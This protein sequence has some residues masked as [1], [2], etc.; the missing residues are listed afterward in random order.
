MARLG[1]NE[2]TILPG[3]LPTAE[4]LVGRIVEISGALHQLDRDMGAASDG[5]LDARIAELRARGAT[6]SD[7]TLKLLLQQR[8][9]IAELEGRRTTLRSQLESASIAL[10]NLRLDV[11]RL[12]SLG[13]ESPAVHDVGQAT[14]QARAL[15]RDLAY[16]ME[17]AR[18]ADRV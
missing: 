5:S 17:G 4:A 2:R 16:L 18:E 13:L 3:V 6:E 15:S 12:G 7:S 14:E 8:K 9:S 10:K 1:S 11:L